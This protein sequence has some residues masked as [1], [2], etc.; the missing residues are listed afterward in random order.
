MDQLLASIKQWNASVPVILISPPSGAPA[1]LWSGKAIAGADFDR[2]MIDYS[3][4]LQ[5]S[6]DTPAAR[7]HGIYVISF[8]GTVAGE[9]MADYVHPKV[10]EG[11][12]DLSPWLAG[13]LA[14]LAADEK[15]KSGYP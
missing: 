11:H 10:P 12:N 13:P 7:A 15:I 6:Y 9:H 8:L 4:K 1:E 3:R 5:A 14:Y 2:R